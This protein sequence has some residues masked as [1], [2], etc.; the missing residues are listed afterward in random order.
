[1][2]ARKNRERKSRRK[3]VEEEREKEVKAR[4]ERGGKLME[5]HKDKELIWM[6]TCWN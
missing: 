2:N 4:A 1:M 6:M 3:G 5:L